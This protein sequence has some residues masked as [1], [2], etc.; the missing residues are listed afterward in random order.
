MNT[1]AKEAK[2]RWGKTEAYRQSEER[3]KNWTEADYQRLKEAGDKWMKNFASQMSHGP[4]SAII[5]KLI[6]EHY[7]NLRTFY[8]PNLELYRGLANMYVDDPRFTK[9]FEKYAKG[10]SVFMKDAMLEYCDKN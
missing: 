4:K 10:L 2:A 7:D 8:E 1:Y 6:A 9:Y 5:Q 3:T